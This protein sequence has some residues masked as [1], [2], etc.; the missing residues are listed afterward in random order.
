LNGGWGDLENFLPLTGRHGDRA[1]FVDNRLLFRAGFLWFGSNGSI[2]LLG[3]GQNFIG[4]RK[5]R[6]RRDLE[7]SAY[8]EIRS[9]GFF[10]SCVSLRFHEGCFSSDGSVSG[11]ELRWVQVE[12]AYVL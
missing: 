7:R 3:R 4:L 12:A 11:S 6:R 9:V 8:I 2:S 5:R 1:I 10:A